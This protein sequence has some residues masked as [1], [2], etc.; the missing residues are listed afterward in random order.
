MDKKLIM[1]LL[2]KNIEGHK[3]RYSQEDIDI[4]TEIEDAIIELDVARAM[5]NSVSDPRLIDI[6]IHTED[7]AKARYDYLISVAKERSLK[8]KIN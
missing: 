8:R 3:E 4:L 2:M 1:D 6:A 7:M 5:F